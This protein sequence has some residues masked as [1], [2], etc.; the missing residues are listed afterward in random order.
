MREVLLKRKIAIY[1]N[2]EIETFFGQREEITVF[3]S[4]P[5]HLRDGVDVMSVDCCSEPAIHTFVE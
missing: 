4:C 2:E 5:S 3:D 1:S